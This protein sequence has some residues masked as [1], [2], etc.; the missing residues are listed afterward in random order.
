ML[1][2]YPDI[3][4]TIEAIC[5]GLGVGADAKRRDGTIRLNLAQSKMDGSKHVGFTRIK[6]E[7][8]QQFGYVVSYGAVIELGMAR[9]RRHKSAA[10]YKEEVALKMRRNVKRVSEEHLDT[11]SQRAAFRTVHFVRDRTSQDEVCHFE[12]DDHSAIRMNSSSTTNQHA[13][14]TVGEG[15]GAVQ[16]DYMD[17]E[18]ASSLYATVYRAARLAD[19]VEVNIA[20][21]KLA[22]VSPSSPSQHM[23]DFYKLQQNPLAEVRRLFFTPEGSYKS[24]VQLEVDSGTDECLRG[25]ETRFLIAEAAMGGPLKKKAMVRTQVGVVARAAGDT[26]LNVVE[27]VNGQAT[28]AASTFYAGTDACGELHDPS[29][30]QLDQVRKRAMWEHHL[31]RY[32]ETLDN[33]TGINGASIIAVKGADASSCEEAK[34]LLERRPV[35]LEMLAS[36]TSKKRLNELKVTHPE[37]A[38]HVAE[39]QAYQEHTERLTH[40]ALNVRSCA[41]VQCKL[42]CAAAPGVDFWYVGGPPL[43]GYPVPYLD[44]GRP[45]HRMR[46][47]DAIA[48]YARDNH[49]LPTAKSDLLPPSRHAL[50]LFERGTKHAPLARFPED[51]LQAAVGAIGDGSVTVDRLQAHFLKL[52]YIRLRRLEGCRKATATKAKHKDVRAAAAAVQQDSIRAAVQAAKAK[53]PPKQPAVGATRRR[54]VADEEGEE[55]AEAGEEAADAAGVEVEAEAAVRSS[56][57]RQRRTISDSSDSSDS[58][59]QGDK[60]ESQ[61]NTVFVVQVLPVSMKPH[62]AALLPCQRPTPLRGRMS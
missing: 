4:D 28:A 1:R 57:K 45:G 31:E 16:H 27:R 20:V 60:S 15:A 7:L 50:E 46:P 48:K 32:R 14:A 41:N 25:G 6:L 24:I 13:T 3:G 23:A 55:A 59:D 9:N 52:H 19:G 8:E 12:R 17:P 54:E 2:R 56:G 21:C 53:A 18:V 26:P 36:K 37:L 11:R 30:G 49:Q 35:L 34:I 29:S 42:M 39:V 61:D 58:S 10:R 51:K 47:E 40:Y 22:K 5:A 44:P 33:A 43:K 62:T 38:Q